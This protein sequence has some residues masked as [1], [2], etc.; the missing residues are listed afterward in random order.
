MFAY[1][2]H[3]IFLTLRAT[4]SFLLWDASYYFLILTMSVNGF[5]IVSHILHKIMDLLLHGLFFTLTPLF[6]II[7]P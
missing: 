4:Y 7:Y 3:S 6:L 2:F 1:F 5:L